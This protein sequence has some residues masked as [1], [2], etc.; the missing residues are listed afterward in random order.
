VA[1]WLLRQRRGKSGLHGKTMADNYRLGQPKGSV[2]QRIT[3]SLRNQEVR[4]KRCGKSAPQTWQHEWH[5]QTPSGAKPN[6][7]G[8]HEIYFRQMLFRIS[9]PGR[10]LEVYGNIN[11]R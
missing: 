11:P 7:G 9:H 6:R 10:L 1:A 2:P 8:A 4:V 5:R 3:A